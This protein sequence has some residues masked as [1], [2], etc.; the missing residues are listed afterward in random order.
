MKCICLYTRD[1]PTLLLDQSYGGLIL[2]CWWYFVW[3]LQLSKQKLIQL[4]KYTNSTV[5][6]A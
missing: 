6:S 1:L 3:F 2:R 4:L 5:S